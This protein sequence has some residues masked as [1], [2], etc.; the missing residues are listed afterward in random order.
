MN[1]RNITLKYMGWCPGVEVAARFVPDREINIPLS[2]RLF[3]ATIAIFL[4]STLIAYTFYPPM[5]E[6]PLQITTYLSTGKQAIFDHEFNE[7]YDYGLLWGREWEHRT[8][9]IFREKLDLSEFASGAE[10]EVE[11]PTFETL[12]EVYQYVREE[13]G[14]PNVVACLA[15]YLLNQT[16]EETYFKIWGEPVDTPSPPSSLIFWAPSWP[17]PRPSFGHTIGDVDLLGHPRGVIYHIVVVR[18]YQ[19]EYGDKIGEGLWIR[20]Q[21][22]QSH[23]EY[24]YEWIWEL[25]VDAFDIFYGAE[26]PRYEVMFIRYPRGQRG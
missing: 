21:N 11:N 18:N 8:I 10:A 9:V 19:M 16:F 12:E 23:G 1:L 22:R 7:S 2:M 4:C 24:N 14:A 15:R 3:T 25:H 6:G 13:V 5:P 17:S 20:K 26:N